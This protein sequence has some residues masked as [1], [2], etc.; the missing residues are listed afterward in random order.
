MAEHRPYH[1]GFLCPRPM[2]MIA[3]LMNVYNAHIILGVFADTKK[4]GASDR[5]SLSATIVGWVLPGY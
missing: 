4:C 3:K 5:A 1:R 2:L